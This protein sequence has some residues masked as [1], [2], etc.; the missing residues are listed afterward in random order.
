MS[1]TSCSS[2]HEGRGLLDEGRVYSMGVGGS[3]SVHN[4]WP[5]GPH[6][7]GVRWDHASWA[8]AAAESVGSS[9]GG[10]AGSSSAPSW[11]ASRRGG[12]RTAAPSTIGR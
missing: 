7:R 8:G 11:A 1:P 2:L 9:R 6:P 5:V 3:C 12:C 10:V 4:P